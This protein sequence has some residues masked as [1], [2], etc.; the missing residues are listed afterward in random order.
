M[1]S[2]KT[3][4]TAAMDSLA[5]DPAVRF[6]GYGVSIGRAMGT[7]KNVPASRM[8]ETPVAE[9]LMV[10]LA[11]GMAL[12]GLKPVVFFERFDF[13]LN[14]MDAIVNHLDKIETLSHGEFKPTMILRIV[15]GN[16]EKPLF[17]GETHVQDFEEALAKL[18]T[19]PVVHLPNDRYIRGEY[20]VAHQAL[21]VHSTAII[22][23]KDMI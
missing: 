20:A 6:V 23:Y 7:L 21:G 18:V 12:K 2:Y 19:F 16:R 13:V 9:N 4:L 1:G 10:G 14:A 22:E 8:L 15:V 3:E 11:I 17:T 5:L